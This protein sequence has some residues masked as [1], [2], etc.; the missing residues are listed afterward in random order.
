[1]KTYLLKSKLNKGLIYGTVLAMSKPFGTS[2]K[3][4]NAL[5]KMSKTL[6]CMEVIDTTTK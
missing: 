2:R 5:T 6:T 4:K 1:M 3:A